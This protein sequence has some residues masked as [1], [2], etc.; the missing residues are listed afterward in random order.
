MVKIWGFTFTFWWE[1]SPTNSVSMMSSK[2]WIQLSLRHTQDKTRI[3]GG[4][5]LP[6]HFVGERFLWWS[7]SLIT[8]YWDENKGFPPNV[9]T[10]SFCS[11]DR[12]IYCGGSIIEQVLQINFTKSDKE[13]VWGFFLGEI[14]WN[15]KFLKI[16]LTHVNNF[17]PITE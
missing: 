9:R 8:F 11:I 1:P 5:K 6:P 13:I 12:C 10:I 17:F 3:L 4:W 7:F 14:D 2:L 16:K 15:R